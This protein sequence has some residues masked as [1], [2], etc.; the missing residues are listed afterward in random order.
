[1]ETTSIFETADLYLRD[2]D[3]SGH[4]NDLYDNGRWRDIDEAMRLI[5]FHPDILLDSHDM[6]KDGGLAIVQGIKDGTA[7][8]VSDGSYKKD[9]PIRPAGTSAFRIAPYANNK[10]EQ[11]ITGY[12]W[13]TGTKEDQSSY[14]SEA[15]GVSG[16]LA[17]LDVLVKYYH[18]ESGSVTIALDG[19]LALQQCAGDWPLSIDQPCFDV[20]QDVRGRLKALPI[21]VDFR[22]VEGH[23]DDKGIV[24]Q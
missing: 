8:I 2:M 6:A 23:Q 14:R 21:T 3:T 4:Y 9:T 10:E 19:L 20:L 13:V 1:V 18:I 12:N 22:W 17:V 15:A 16:A 7:R 11:C 5:Q 24:M